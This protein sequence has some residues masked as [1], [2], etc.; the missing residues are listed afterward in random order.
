M[1]HSFALV[2][3]LLGFVFTTAPSAFAQPRFAEVY[4]FELEM[5]QQNCTRAD[6][7][8][9][10]CGQ[11]DHRALFEVFLDEVPADPLEDVAYEGVS[12]P[13]GLALN[14]SVQYLP[15]IRVRKSIVAGTSIYTVRFS[16]R[17]NAEGAPTFETIYIE[18]GQQLELGR[19]LTLMADRL[20]KSPRFFGQVFFTL[21]KI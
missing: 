5:N 18:D 12:E 7:A 10:V 4:R 19:R 9:Y 8:D 21:N 6:G 15:Q 3:F 16:A 11:D 14:A 17:R 2:A 1:K 20:E 13:T